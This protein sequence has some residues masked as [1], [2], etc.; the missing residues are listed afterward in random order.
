MLHFYDGPKL[1]EGMKIEG[2]ENADIPEPKEILNGTHIKS[3]TPS[4]NTQTGE[5]YVSIQLNDEG[6]KIF[7]EYTGAHQG[8]QIYI[9]LDDQ[10]LSF[11][12][13]SAHITDGSGSISGNFTLESVKDLADGINAGSLPFTLQ[14]ISAQGVGAKLGMTALNTSMLAGIIGFILILIYMICMYR[15]CG[16]AADIALCLYV[17]LVVLILTIMNATLTL[18]GIAGILLSI[19]MAVDAN[20]II[21]ARIKEELD[22]GKSVR[23]AVDSG[24]NKALWAIVDGNVTTLVAAV[25]LY[26]FGTGLI[27]SFATTLIV[28]IVVSLFTALVITSL[29]L[30]AFVGLG[31]KDAKLFAK[32]KKPNAPDKMP[33]NFIG[34]RVK[35]YIGSIIVIALGII[36]MIVNASTGKGAFNQD[37]EFSGGSLIQVNMGQAITTDMRDDIT[38]I[39]KDTTGVSN[40]RITTAGDT[41]VIVTTP[42]L[43]ADARTKL[44][45]AI[46]GK[47]NLG[48]DALESD[49]SFSASISGDIKKGAIEAVVVGVIIILLYITWRFRNFKMGTSAVIALCHDVLVMFA[50][51]AI[52]R[53]PLNNSFIAAMLTIVGY[54]INDTIVVFDR[55]RENR[56]KAGSTNGKPTE[57]I[58]NKSLSQTM[59]RSISTSLTTVVIVL[60]LFILGPASVKEFAFPLIIGILAGTYSSLCVASPIWFDMSK[61]QKDSKPAS[62]NNSSKKSSK[63]KSN[64]QK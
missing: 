59:G 58:I 24:F 14:A 52:F 54:S 12:T 61:N 13:L 34:N 63:N 60:L 64:K 15:L 28:G 49:E 41:S 32:V 51:Y 6:T 29:I 20:V 42:T 44:F 46:K 2:L 35:F 26:F 9:Y 56:T 7:D 4:Q 19:G 62:K 16:V 23:F 37:I 40:V 39:T 45:E 3:A 8:E 1:S 27:K 50:A 36:F 38:N 30:K 33:F 47:Y 18:P 10:L 31:I 53:V 5:Y 43:D 25:V 57:A 21:F 17:G 11:P 55:I 48:E 22:T